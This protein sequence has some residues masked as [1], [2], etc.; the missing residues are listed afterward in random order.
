MSVRFSNRE[1][2]K[3]PALQ[4]RA[5]PPA[6]TK[7][8]HVS[9]M[10][11]LANRM[12]QYM[13]ALA[14]AA[15][16]PG[17]QIAK[18]HLPEWGI[19]T[20]P[21]VPDD[22][23]GLDIVTTD[24]IDLDHLA[25][26]LNS[27]SVIGVDLQTYAQRMENFLPVE[28]YREV[29]RP[30]SLSSGGCGP[31]ELLINIRQGDIIDGHHAD[32]VLIPA[33]FYAELI[34]QT[35]L[36]PVF[37]GQLDETPYLADLKSRFPNARFLPRRG[38][39]AD[40]DCIRRSINI[41][42]SVS[43]F[44]WLAAW[45]S[46]AQHIFM[47]VL[48]LLHPLQCRSVRLLPLDDPRYRFYVFPHHYAVPVEQFAPAHA[49]LRGLWRQMQPDRLARLLD[50]PGPPRTRAAHLRAF[51]E[52]FYLTLYPDIA[53]AVANGHFPS[54]RDHYDM[55][56]FAEGRAPCSDVDK[57]WY[58]QAYPIAAVEL[59]QGEALDPMHHWIETGQF[60][61]Y[62]RRPAHHQEPPR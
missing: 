32:Y 19:Q 60:R 12:I 45:L 51:D 53:E 10:G 29:F 37:M 61:G 59:G 55:F 43:T 54:G 30:P 41:V 8:I 11:N 57:A 39:Q 15:R 52:D 47:P 27:R 25:A 46:E 16:V 42:P 44:G 34:E 50:A 7:L 21:L 17:A 2:N 56:G 36:R 3:R 18:V 4:R 23:P 28:A 20:P 31:D 40:F 13:A 33:D 26:R 9:P 38:P 14:L 22:H 35:G 24:T 49:S 5:S 1:K 62:A 58:C 6:A 48:G